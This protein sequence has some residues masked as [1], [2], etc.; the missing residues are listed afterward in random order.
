METPTSSPTLSVAV[1]GCGRPLKTEGATGFG[2]AHRHMAGFT[3]SGRCQLAAVVDINR[4]NAEA[5]VAE[6]NPEAAIFA[7]HREMME[8]VNPDIVS[9]CL[10]P[11]LH[12][13]VVCAIAPRRPRIIYCE[14]PMDIHWDAAVRMHEACRRHGVLLAFNH[15]RRFNLPIMKAREMLDAGAIGKLRQIEAAWHNLSDT[16]TH[17]LDLMFFF[18]HDTPADWV[19]GQIDMRAAKRVF[20]A[21]QTGQGFSEFRFSNG[22]RATYRFG[23]QHEEFGYL[24]KLH[25]D[26]G[27]IEV[28][29]SEPWLRAR[30]FG[31]G[32]W[33]WIDT[34]ESIHD[35]LG[36][37]RAIAD[38]LACHDA[39]TTP[40]LASDNAIRATEVLFATAES[41]RRRGRIDLPLAPA[42]CALLTMIENGE[43]TVV[44]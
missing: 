42:P 38:V 19:L 30:R 24:I 17:V 8:R 43:M 20:G 5:F 11:H 44:L 1:I 4:A 29:L 32:A 28:L 34:G 7:D 39:G 33:Q 15:Q 36:I 14:K 31:D 37:Y 18:N 2:M 21:V 6:H 9:V 12:A 40:Q 10:W 16:G 25:G 13:E 26:D 41:A 22:V 27:V 35:D 23:A 3:R